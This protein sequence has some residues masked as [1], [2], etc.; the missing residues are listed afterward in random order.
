MYYKK[1]KRYSKHK[2]KL[3]IMQLGIIQHYIYELL[4]VQNPKCGDQWIGNV[5]LMELK[6]CGIVVLMELKNIYEI[7]K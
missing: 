3:N 7:T 5:G 1:N 2:K 6:K 4:N